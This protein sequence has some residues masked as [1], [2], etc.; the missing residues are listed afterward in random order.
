[1]EIGVGGRMMSEL[2]DEVSFVMNPKCTFNYTQINSTTI[3]YFPSCPA[4]YGILV[5]NLA[6]DL[7]IGQLRTAFIN[8]KK[9]FGGIRIENTK[10]NTLNMFS[11]SNFKF[12]CDYYGFYAI[13][14]SQLSDATFLKEMN[15]QTSEA[16]VNCHFHIEN[17]P[18]LDMETLCAEGF[19]ASL[20]SIK[21]KGNLK[22]CGCQGDEITSSNLPEYTDCTTLYN[23]LKLY[24]LTDVSS[25]SALSNIE[26]IRGDIRIENTLIQNLSFLVNWKSWKIRNYGTVILNIQN[27]SEFTSLPSSFF[28]MLETFRLPANT[29]NPILTGNFENSHP[30]FCVS[31]EQI[32]GIFEKKMSFDTFQS[33]ICNDM[34]NIEENLVCRFV[35]MTDLPNNCDIILGNLIIEHGDEGFLVKLRGISTVIGSV[36]IRN[37]EL[38]NFKDIASN[39]N[40]ISLDDSLPVIQ[41]V[42]NK[43]LTDIT[44][45]SLL[46]VITRGPREAVIQDNNPKLFQD[47]VPCKI[48]Q[49]YGPSGSR[50]YRTRLN[51]TGEDCGDRVEVKLP[52]GSNI[53]S[54][55][56]LFILTSVFYITD[57]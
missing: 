48:S 25:L 54:I 19:L 13:N 21:T 46:N 11:T 43:N 3:K 22:N 16:L 7:L 18:H 40:I 6:T 47:G 52:S 30:E 12:Y 9:L 35:S 2:I 23:G 8:M 14:N 37:T 39:L 56:L 53:P 45:N 28:K 10:W 36:I 1:M 34:G 42:G 41:I 49:T 15:S 4:V 29:D 51:I 26:N 31:I 5:I 50:D 27:N 55:Y 24:N 32:L 38:E 57:L 33:R 44:F 17:N 20:T